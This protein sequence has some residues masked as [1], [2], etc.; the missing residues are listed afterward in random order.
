M[1]YRG[2][3]DSFQVKIDDQD[4]E[5]LP[6]GV[7]WRLDEDGYAVGTGYSKEFRRKIGINLARFIMGNP[8]G[9]VVD[10]INGDRRDNRRCNLR[11]C[12]KHQNS[13]N[14]KKPISGKTSQFKGVYRQK[15]NP[16]KWHAAIKFQGKSRYLGSYATELEAAEAY[17]SAA[18]FYFGEYARIA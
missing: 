14:R 1:S 9:M 5:T 12:T 3:F 15:N 16:A 10:H 13:F 4:L 6:Y 17:K 2:I 11:V 7:E 8:E 18:L